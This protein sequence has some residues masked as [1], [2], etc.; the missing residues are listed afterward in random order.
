MTKTQLFSGSGDFNIGVWDLSTMQYERSMQGHTDT[1][2][3]LTVVDDT[4]LASGRHYT[5]HMMVI[6][7]N[8]SLQV[9]VIARSRSGGWTPAT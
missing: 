4:Y 3:A 2:T 1:V 9:V 7:H 5:V 6:T 8:L